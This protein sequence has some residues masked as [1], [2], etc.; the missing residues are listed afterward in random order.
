MSLLASYNSHVG[1]LVK[2]AATDEGNFVGQPV[3]ILPIWFVVLKELTVEF[4]VFADL[5]HD[6]IFFD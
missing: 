3:N 2:I 5:N 6:I 4:E 1:C